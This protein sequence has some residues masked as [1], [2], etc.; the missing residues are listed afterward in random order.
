MKDTLNILEGTIKAVE[1][2]TKVLKKAK[3]ELIKLDKD[4]VRLKNEMLLLEGEKEQLEA[5]KLKLEQDTKNLKQETIK[6]E[7][8]KQERDQKIGAMTE[9]Q[10]KLLDEYKALKVELKKFA[11]AA[12]EAEETEFNFERIK[13]L[14]SIYTV[15][16]D[17]IFQGQPHYKI[18]EVLHGGKEKMTKDEL[19]N[20]TGIG[21][22]FILRSVQELDKVGL[23]EYDVDN[24]TAKLKKRLFP[25]KALE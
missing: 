3:D 15:L 5:E 11:K 7:K 1:D 18:L 25:K 12:A 17:K 23:V 10:L 4:K 6:L 9:E 14:L 24:G 8:E 16:I 2:I 22:I 19:K 13:A 21:G 20:T